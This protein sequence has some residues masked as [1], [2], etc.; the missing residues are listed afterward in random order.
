MIKMRCAT[1]FFHQ[2]FNHNNI[3]LFSPTLMANILYGIIRHNVH[4]D[5]K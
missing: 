4:R 1:F 5:T 2:H 3:Y